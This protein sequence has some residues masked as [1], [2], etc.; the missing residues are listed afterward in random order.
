MPCGYFFI[1][2][3]NV[4]QSLRLRLIRR[5]EGSIRLIGTITTMHTAFFIMV[6][7]IFQR[8]ITLVVI[9]GIGSNEFMF[10]NFFHHWRKSRLHHFTQLG[11]IAIFNDGILLAVDGFHGYQPARTIQVLVVK[12]SEFIVI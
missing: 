10:P 2:Y 5:S 4:S 9:V 6:G 7:A 8:A 11:A 1:Y 3:S 12:L